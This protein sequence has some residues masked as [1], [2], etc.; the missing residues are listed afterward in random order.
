MEQVKD[1]GLKGKVDVYLY[2]LLHSTHWEDKCLPNTH[3]K[4]METILLLEESKRAY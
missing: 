4:K 3:Q 2:S 1:K